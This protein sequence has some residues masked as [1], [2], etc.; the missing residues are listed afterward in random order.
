M[1]FRKPTPERE[2]LR[3][4]IACEKLTP[5]EVGRARKLLD[6]LAGGRLL[7][8]DLENRVWVERLFYA[9]KLGSQRP[10]E[11]T[12][13]SKPTSKQLIAAFDA[14]PRPKKPPGKG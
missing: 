8:L 5:D 11:A 12:K 6:D 3:L 13:S 1:P 9:H 7:R 2:M 14:M 4:L 10:R